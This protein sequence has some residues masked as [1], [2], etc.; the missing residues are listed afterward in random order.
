VARSVDQL[1]E[2]CKF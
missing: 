2:S 1:V